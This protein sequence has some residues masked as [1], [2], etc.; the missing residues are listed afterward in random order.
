MVDAGGNVP[1]IELRA[2]VKRFGATEVLN[3]VD[4]TVRR[5]ELFSLL[6]PSGCGKTPF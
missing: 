4:L 1:Q 2:V 6:G 3:R 5:G